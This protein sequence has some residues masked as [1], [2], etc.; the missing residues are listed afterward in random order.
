MKNKFSFGPGSASLLRCADPAPTIQSQ[1]KA[2]AFK[3][4]AHVACQAMIAQFIGSL[5]G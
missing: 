5:S 4:E 1:R 2:H 3:N